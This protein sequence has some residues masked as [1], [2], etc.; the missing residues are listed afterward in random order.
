MDQASDSAELDIFSS[1]LERLKGLL[2]R[3]LVDRETV[4]ALEAK[5]AVLEKECGPA[6]DIMRKIKQALDP[7]N[8]MNPG[9][10]LRY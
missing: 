1:Q 6:V 4:S 7:D 9:K 2:T 3:G 10:V 8:L 5:I